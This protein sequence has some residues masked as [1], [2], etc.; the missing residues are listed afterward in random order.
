M[1]RIILLCSLLLLAGCTDPITEHNKNV[2]ET[3]NHTKDITYK[4]NANAYIDAVIT[5]YNKYL[6]DHNDYP[7]LNDIHI[8]YDTKACNNDPLSSDYALKIE[9]GYLHIYCGEY[10]SYTYDNM[11][12]KEM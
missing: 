6:A 11:K 5:E 4:E 3:I 10:A 7:T 2:I 8:N 1:K 12:V 9:N